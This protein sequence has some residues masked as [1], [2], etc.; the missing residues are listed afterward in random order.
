MG[1]AACAAALLVSVLAPLAFAD[2]KT[3]GRVHQHRQGTPAS[4]CTETDDGGLARRLL[5]PDLVGLRGGGQGQRRDR[6]G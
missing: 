5:D 3:V 4:A 6:E 1:L 2:H